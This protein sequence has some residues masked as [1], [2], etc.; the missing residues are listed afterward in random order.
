M[1]PSAEVTA[2]ATAHAI[3][4]DL[5]DLIQNEFPLVARPYAAFAEKLGVDEETVIGRIAALREAGQIRQVSAIFDTRRLGY[6]SMLAAAKVTGDQDAVDRAA[7]IFSAH[8]G[9]THNYLRD[10]DLNLWFTLAVPPDSKMGLEATID[11]LGELAN[12]D[13]LRHMPSKKFFKIGVDLDVKGDRSPN[14]KK[15]LA[16]PIEA[17]PA[18]ETLT[19]RDKD[20]IRALQVDLPAIARPF[21]QLAEQY[22]FD[23]Q[24]LI[25]RGHAFLRTGQMRRFAAVLAHRKAGFVYNGMGVWKVPAE[26]LD[27]I[28]AIMAGFRGVSHCYERPT[29]PGWPYNIFSMTH[30]REKADC[31][32]VLSAIAEEI[33][34]TKDDYIVL[35]STKEYK[36]TRVSYFTPEM[37]AWEDVHAPLLANA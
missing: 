10:H 9:V 26:R 28:G 7:A 3:D 6:R 15:A 20:A 30:G 23:E 36:K 29:Y 22:G 11:L 19:D 37:Y 5:L 2:P 25:D 21:L 18:P 27:E 13:V 24:E 12:V 34:V 32:N 1:D 16:R 31:E 14:A 33:G 35:Y 17:A 8:P 4:Q